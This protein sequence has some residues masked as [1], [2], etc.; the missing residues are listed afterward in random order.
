MNLRSIYNIISGLKSSDHGLQ[1]WLMQKV[2]AIILIPTSLL[3]IYFF[4]LIIGEN[5]Q[6]VTSFFNNKLI[7]AI[8]AIFIITALIHLRQGLQVVIEDYVHNMRLNRLLLK[9]ISLS[10]VV[11]SVAAAAALGKLALVG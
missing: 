1:H 4:S 8:T 6:S 10:T 2:T 9:I 7:C 11:L 5:H 3:F